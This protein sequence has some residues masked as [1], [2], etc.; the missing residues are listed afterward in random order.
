MGA[1]GGEA[2]RIQQGAGRRGIVMPGAE[3]LDIVEA[4]RLGDGEL[5]LDRGKVPRA[6][7][8][9]AEGMGKRHFVGRPPAPI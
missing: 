1:F 4:G 9:Q 7:E 3:R 5:P 2:M 6:V 8:L